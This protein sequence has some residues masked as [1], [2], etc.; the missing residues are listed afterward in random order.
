MWWV[1][2]QLV[3]AK[4]ILPRKTDG[5]Q[6]ELICNAAHNNPSVELFWHLDENFIGSTTDIHQITII[7]T[8]GAHK[9]T[10]FDNLGLKQTIEIIIK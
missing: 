2:F 1:P 8:H 9:L 3:D 5:T 6:S 4:I 7:P 10:L